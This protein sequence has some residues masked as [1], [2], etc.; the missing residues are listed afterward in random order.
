MS[1]INNI[2]NAMQN[3][4][5]K[6]GIAK[7]VRTKTFLMTNKDEDTLFASEREFF[8]ETFK[9]KHLNLHKC[10]RLREF[11]HRWADFRGCLCW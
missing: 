7:Q 11:S 8:D 6:S 2:C 3:S 9:Q 5:E 4:F 10:L 1:K